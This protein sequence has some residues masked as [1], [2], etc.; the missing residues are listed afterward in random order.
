MS[1]FIEALLE[2]RRPLIMEV[3]R[4]DPHGNDLMG[5]R[6]VAEVVAHYET[7][8]AACV[9]VVTGRWFGGTPELLREVVDR[10]GK[11]VL[12]K[13]FITRRDHIQQA[14]RC[15]AAAVLL[16]AG[17]LTRSSLANLIDAALSLELT[18]FVEITSE[19]EITGI[20]SASQCVIAVNNKDI[21]TGERDTGDLTRSERMLPFLRASGTRAPVSA[22]GIDTPETAARL[23][24]LGYAGLLV[25]TALLRAPSVGDWLDAFDN[26][27][28]T[29]FARKGA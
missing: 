23:A 16:T 22:S 25:G 4:R 5:G 6:T 1:V 15:G 24:D 21:K 18:P 7:A 2:A 10:T 12:Q 20:T 27:R 11:P 3:K 13:D 8:G 28:T 29:E 19:D 26:S 17:L 14:R 9:S